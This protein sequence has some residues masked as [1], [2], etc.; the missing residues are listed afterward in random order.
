MKMGTIFKAQSKPWHRYNEKELALIDKEMEEEE[1]RGANP[2]YWE[3][4]SVGDEV[5]P[6]IK[7]PITLS[8]IAV[9]MAFRGALPGCEVRRLAAK[10]DNTYC[11]IDPRTG[12]LFGDYETHIDSELAQMLGHVRAYV[13]G[14]QEMEWCGH[15]ITNWMG[16]DGFLKMINTRFRRI[17]YAGD[18]I[19]VKGKVVKKYV[20]NSEHLVDIDIQ[21]INWDGDINITG[22]ATVLLPSKQS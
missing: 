1:I 4:V 7:G 16:D 3:D 13:S 12:D 14:C 10:S 8:D 22:S 5:K 2:R 21:G 19:R 6:V 9:N 20:E 11:G 15:L 17:I 18:T